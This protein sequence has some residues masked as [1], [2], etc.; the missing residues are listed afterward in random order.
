MN[1]LIGKNVRTSFSKII[2]ESI[3]DTTYDLFSC[4][5]L[6]VI[7]S[8]DFQGLNITNP[9][10]QEVIM[11]LDFLDDEAKKI[12][13][14]NTV[15]KK[16]NLLYGYNTDYYGFTK[17][18][19]KFDISL[20][21]KKVLILGNG[22]TAQMVY[23]AA[24]NNKAKEISFLVRT[25]RADNEYLL[26]QLQEL[27][28][29]DIIINT[30][31]IGN[32]NNDF[33]PF[34]LNFSLFTSLEAVIDLN[35]NPL[36]SKLLLEARKY[37]KKAINGLYMLVS[38]ALK[39]NSLLT[40][41]LE[42]LKKIDSIYDKIHSSITNVVLIGMPGSGKSSI[43]KRLSYELNKESLDSDIEFERKYHTS[44]SAYLKNNSEH[45][46]REK[47][48]VIIKELSILNNKI[49]ATGGGVILDEENIMNLRKNS[50]LIFINRNLELLKENEYSN[51]PLI[52]SVKD[53]EETYKIRINK[54]IAAADIIVDNNDSIGNCINEIKVKL[55]EIFNN[56]WT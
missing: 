35:Y 32:V 12:G 52:K 30:T 20:E 16:N 42:V 9:Y 51:R 38:Q 15:I 31:P 26:Y 36:N 41:N 54:Y 29:I 44:T 40:N 34:D 37:K 55:N 49:I 1:G 33:I 14:V 47:E 19:E 5:N 4:D 24:I 7:K 18:L 43:S 50:I 17:T 46:F 45:K 8:L 28:N 6:E 56:Q 21:N 13:S 3:S 27:L 11:Y 22:A 39:A 53:L 2:H 25:K 23:F 48:K 10:K